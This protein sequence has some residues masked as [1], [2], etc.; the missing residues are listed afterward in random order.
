M[1]TWPGHPGQRHEGRLQRHECR[2]R[3]TASRLWR[4]WSKRVFARRTVEQI[5]TYYALCQHESSGVYLCPLVSASLTCKFHFVTLRG[6]SLHMAAW[7][8]RHFG[9][10]HCDRR[11]DITVA[12][13]GD[14]GCFRVSVRRIGEEETGRRGTILTAPRK[15]P[16]W[17][18]CCVLRPP[19][20]SI[21]DPSTTCPTR[22]L[23]QYHLPS[24]PL[25]LCPLLYSHLRQICHAK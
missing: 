13:T 23:S 24:I 12:S 9:L 20:R 21:P 8:D 15:D 10:R 16:A 25:Y 18:A 19:K 4:I 7:Q 1:S 2:H 3:Y 5:S 14:D 6:P 17:L 11:A 22:R